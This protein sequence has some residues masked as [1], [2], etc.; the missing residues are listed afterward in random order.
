MYMK[1]I[2]AKLLMV[3]CLVTAPFNCDYS[4]TILRLTCRGYC[5]VYNGYSTGIWLGVHQSLRRCTWQRR[6]VSCVSSSPPAPFKTF[7]CNYCAIKKKKRL[8]VEELS[9]EIAERVKYA[10]A[11]EN[12]FLSGRF[13]L[14]LDCH[15]PRGLRCWRACVFRSFCFPRR[16]KGVLVV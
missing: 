9:S 16:K 5:S 15:L 11:L 3:K 7:L 1:S 2:S 12:F 4:A 10:S 8:P 6:H 13:F 14:P